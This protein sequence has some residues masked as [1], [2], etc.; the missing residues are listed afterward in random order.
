[1]WTGELN[2]NTTT[3]SPMSR[4]ARGA[5][6]A[7]ATAVIGLG[8]PTVG[9]ADPGPAPGP[10]MGCETIHWGMFGDDR[11]RICDGPTQ[12]DGSWQR[13]RTVYTPASNP[14]LQCFNS[15]M[16]GSDGQ[17]I[18]P[19]NFHCS[20]GYPVPESVSAHETYPVSPGTVLP[21]EPGWLPPYTDN[22]L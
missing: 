8:V 1:M 5:V 11:R 10:G 19:H 18:G 22:V 20:G 13:T 7:A 6:L 14:P 17:A 16:T 3:S 12:P 15:D 21:D 2:V 4:V 9:H